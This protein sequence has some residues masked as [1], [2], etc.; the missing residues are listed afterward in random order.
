MRAIKNRVKKNMGPSKLSY[1]MVRPSIVAAAKDR[2]RKPG[3]CKGKSVCY[4]Y[5]VGKGRTEE[6]REGEVGHEEP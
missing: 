1:C 3:N 5:E 4:T 2:T 6:E